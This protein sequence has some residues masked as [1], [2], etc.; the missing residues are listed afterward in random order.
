MI[1]KTVNTIRDVDQIDKLNKS[2]GRKFYKNTNGLINNVAGD[3]RIKKAQL[4][5]DYTPQGSS[6]A[7]QLRE[8]GVL[9]LGEIYDEEVLAPIRETYEEYIEDPEKSFVRSEYDGEVYSRSILRCHERLPE[10]GSLL[11]N[12]IR[13][14]VKEYYQS[15][16]RVLHM[17]AWRNHHVPDDIIKESEI[18]SDSWHCDGRTTEVLKLFV[19][20]SDVTEDHGPFQILPR[21]DTIELVEGGY[22]RTRNQM[23]DE[24]VNEDQVVKATGAAGTAM[25]CNTT[26]CFHRAGHVGE[27]NIRDIIQFQFVPA[28]EPLPADTNDWIN[29]VVTHP[30]EP[31]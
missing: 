26:K 24:F 28:D 3:V 10:L 9:E 22:Q 5:S 15:H 1:K 4:A 23:P 25:L 2:M 7:A 27:G 8:T 14:L 21:S 12:E 6:E 31:N 29:S 16:F 18:Y 30:S 20:L 11:T 13:D 17:N 19:C